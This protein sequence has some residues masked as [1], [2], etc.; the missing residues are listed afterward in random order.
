MRHRGDVITVGETTERVVSG[1]LVQFTSGLLIDLRFDS[2]VVL[3]ETVEET[4]AVVHTSS[5]SVAGVDD[6]LEELLVPAGHEVSVAAV[7]S[8]VTVGED[9]RLLAL[10]LSPAA[11]EFVS[12]PVG[13][14][15]EMRNMNPA[16]GAVEVAVVVL[17]V[18]HVVLEVG[19]ASLGVITRREVDISSE[20]R[21]LAV[22]S[23]V[24]E[25]NTLTLVDRITDTSCGAVGLGIPRGG[26]VIV[27]GARTGHSGGIDRALGGVQVGL[28][29]SLGHGAGH[30][31]ASNN[32]QTS[33]ERLDL[34]V[35]LLEADEGLSYMRKVVG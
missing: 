17:G 24:R 2:A 6:V 21:V 27:I 14:V 3:V 35:C 18:G 5:T 16:L 13:L 10:S 25:S 23:S 22:T 30:G 11:L 26:R 19:K 20:R 15:K 34:I 7:T 29:T 28:G 1:Q 32:L 33:G 31:I 8:N 4:R 12:V 9:K